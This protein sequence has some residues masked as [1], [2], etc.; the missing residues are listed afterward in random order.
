M[1]IH[2]AAEES[3]MEEYLL[4][5]DTGGWIGLHDKEMGMKPVSLIGETAGTSNR[6]A[7]TYLPTQQPAC[8]VHTTHLLIVFHI[9]VHAATI[10]LL[11]AK[12]ILL[13]E[14]RVVTMG[15][16]LAGWSRAAATA[17]FKTELP[18]AVV[19]R[20]RLT[21]TRVPVA[22]CTRR[23]GL[24]TG[25]IT[26]VAVPSPIPGGR[27]VTERISHTMAGTSFSEA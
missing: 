8:L 27:G 13:L 12:P 26:A 5:D 6:C 4:P 3:L 22:R 23:S 25:V 1:S 9:A 10:M 24:T 18:T 17:A 15:P 21:S 11:G 14:S 7:P 16:L 19:R 20:L 2:S